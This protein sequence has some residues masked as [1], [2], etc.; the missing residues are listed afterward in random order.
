MNLFDM[1]GTENMCS[2][3]AISM[4]QNNQSVHSHKLIFH[5]YLLF[6]KCNTGSDSFIHV[7]HSGRHSVQVTPKKT[8]HYIH[9]GFNVKL[10]ILAMIW[11]IAAERR[12]HGAKVQK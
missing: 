7:C 4:C 1:L 8:L 6:G 10:Q 9:L 3:R 2:S 12:G 5:S 11:N